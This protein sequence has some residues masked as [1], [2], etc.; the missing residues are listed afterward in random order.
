MLC[1]MK[2]CSMEIKLS[3]VFLGEEKHLFAKM[4]MVYKTPSPN[5]AGLWEV[6]NGKNIYNFFFSCTC[7]CEGIVCKPI[8]REPAIFYI[9]DSLMILATIK[10]IGKTYHRITFS[11]HILGIPKDYSVCTNQTSPIREKETEKR[12][13]R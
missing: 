5:S 11:I 9:M 7:T 6:L 1:F 4:F 8:R 10:E 13:R 2:E 3:D 12:K